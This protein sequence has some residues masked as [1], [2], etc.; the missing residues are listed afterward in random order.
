[1]HVLCSQQA[2][3]VWK[4]KVVELNVAPPTSDAILDVLALQTPDEISC[5]SK[6]SE[7]QADK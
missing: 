6:A 4:K 3:N 5:R 1:M 7:H 2:G